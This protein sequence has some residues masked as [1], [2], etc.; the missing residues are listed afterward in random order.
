MMMET[1][2]DGFPVCQI[3]TMKTEV[4][5]QIG[6]W[7]T[8]RNCSEYTEPAGGGGKAFKIPLL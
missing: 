6:K 8:E 3:I 7:H 1:A 4:R 5:G 2:S